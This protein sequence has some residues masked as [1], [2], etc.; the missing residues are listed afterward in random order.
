MDRHVLKL[1]I[2]VTGSLVANRSELRLGRA[3]EISDTTS[4]LSDP[5]VHLFGAPGLGAMQASFL[6]EPTHTQERKGK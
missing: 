4:W 6:G 1:L 2:F 5:T 3:S